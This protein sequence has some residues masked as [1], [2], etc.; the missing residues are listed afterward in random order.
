[1]LTHGVYGDTGKHEPL[2]STSLDGMNART[3][4]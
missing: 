4:V 1:M 3:L 2:A